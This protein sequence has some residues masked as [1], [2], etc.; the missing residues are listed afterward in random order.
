MARPPDIHGSNSLIPVWK[1]VGSLVRAALASALVPPLLWE[2]VVPGEAW[3]R[4][5]LPIP[6]LVPDQEMLPGFQVQNNLA[7]YRCCPR[8]EGLSPV[9]RRVLVV[10]L[11]AWYKSRFRPE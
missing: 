2:P 7:G 8:E 6:S 11:R 3:L 1:E 9:N 5:H 10:H 4:L